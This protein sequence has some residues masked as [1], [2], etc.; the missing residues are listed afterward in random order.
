MVEEEGEGESEDWEMHFG[1]GDWVNERGLW[2]WYLEL[3]RGV[4]V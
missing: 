3:A 1:W 2:K 4:R